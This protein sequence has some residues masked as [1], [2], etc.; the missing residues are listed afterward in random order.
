MSL[1]LIALFV[2]A[3]QLATADNKITLV[4]KCGYTIWPGFQGNPMI[5]PSG[6]VLPAGQSKT[7]TLKDHTSAARIWAR[8]GCTG[9]DGSTFK[10]Q[11][12]D[13]GNRIDCQGRGGA[14]PCSL[15]EFTLATNGYDT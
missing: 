2:V 11:T 10:C 8:T 6:F 7:I 4:N 14:V 15:A 1:K 9:N 12:G 3:L 13:C 5:S